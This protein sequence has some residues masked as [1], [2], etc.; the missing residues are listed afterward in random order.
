MLLMLVSTSICAPFG[1]FDFIGDFGH[2]KK[3]YHSPY[4]QKGDK[5]EVIASSLA[6]TCNTFYICRCPD[7]EALDDCHCI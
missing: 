7:P 5:C 4:A 2:K 6:L 3:G 1:P